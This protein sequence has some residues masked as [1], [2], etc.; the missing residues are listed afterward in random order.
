MISKT[1]HDTR[2]SWKSANSTKSENPKTFQDS[3][4][5]RISRKSWGSNGQTQNT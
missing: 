4:N 5:P 1:S 3:A 2:D